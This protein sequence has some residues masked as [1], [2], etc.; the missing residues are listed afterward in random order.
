VEERPVIVA[1]ASAP[2]PALRGVVRASGPGALAIAARLTGG[3]GV[4]RCDGRGGDSGRSGG[5][6]CARG[7]G[8]DPGDAGD[9]G[10]GHGGCDRPGWRGIRAARL[11]SPAPPCAC[12]VLAAP[13]P[14]SAT[15]E[16]C[17]EFHLPG[18]P[19]LLERVVDAFVAVADGHARRAE[20]GEFSAR[21]VLTG[22]VSIAEAERVAGV[23]AAATDA[24]LEAAEALRANAAGAVARAVADELATLL[25][26]VEAG[27]DFTDQEGVVAIGAETLAA[28]ARAAADRLESLARASAGVEAAVAAPLVVLAGAPNAGK[29]SLFNALL[30]RARAVAAPVAG[31]TRDVLREP[32]ALPGG[33]TVLL[34]DLPGVDAAAGPLDLAVQQ[35]AEEALAAADVVVWCAPVGPGG[36]DRSCAEGAE[37][38]PRTARVRSV[39]AAVRAPVVEART[40]ADLATARPAAD[41]DT[42]VATS[43]RDGTGVEALKHAVARALAERH[44]TRG[45]ERLALGAAQRSLLEGSVNALREAAALA[46]ADARR[47]SPEPGVHGATDTRG[48]PG[49]T[50]G[51]SGR[52]PLAQPEV[53]AAL[54]RTALDRL[55]GVAGEIPPDDV[56]GRLFAHFC[57]GK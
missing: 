57:V 4:G 24:Q 27:I 53:V 10:R 1:V 55:G 2:G 22:R 33:V 45:G 46:W 29:S 36:A 23:I 38:G 21:S 54:L 25:A 37:P 9:A 15:G 8:S 41:T 35:R 6:G 56:L 5:D 39:R 40:K 26:L 31:T 34:A 30:G 7:G 32:L 17:V 3:G 48:A 20:P 51:P 16:D 19:A 11:R 28:R 47:A 52:T 18:N 14:R 43:A 50:R 12:L 13:A 44:S 49:S 42:R